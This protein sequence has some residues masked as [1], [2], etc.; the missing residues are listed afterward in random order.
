MQGRSPRTNQ[1]DQ[2]VSDFFHSTTFKVAAAIVGSIFGIACLGIIIVMLGLGGAVA[3]IWHSLVNPTISAPYYG[4][5]TLAPFSVTAVIHVPQSQNTPTPTQAN[6][7]T[8]TPIYIPVYDSESTIWRSPDLYDTQFEIPNDWT[9]TETD[10]QPD[11]MGGGHEC[12]NYL[13]GSS[14]STKFIKIT[15]PCGAVD[16]FPAAS[17]PVGTVFVE[18]VGNDRYL[19][20]FPDEI[21]DGWVYQLAWQS[22]EGAYTCSDSL[23]PPV[24]V[25]WEVGKHYTEII[26]FSDADR[27]IISTTQP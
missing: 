8:D 14:D 18:P 24:I 9:L 17:C 15:M 20:R 12:V 10:R 16:A 19:I 1:F 3:S 27:I 4:I 7:S 22:P 21:Q 25:Y 26:D 6:S 13:L 5:P 11:P 2:M 23:M